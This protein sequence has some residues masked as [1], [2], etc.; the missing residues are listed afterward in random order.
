MFLPL[1]R[2]S[3]AVVLAVVASN[4]IASKEADMMEILVEQ[5]LNVEVFTA[6]KFNQKRSE[7]PSRVTVVD[8]NAIRKYGY[9]TLKDILA[10]VP[11]L[12]ASNDRNYTYLGV[13]GFGLAGDYNT[14][15]L[16]LLD[17]QRVNENVYDS[18]GA[19]Y[20]SIVNV[21]LIKRVEFSSGEVI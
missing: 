20:E 8:D 21:D 15:I 13:R 5:L 3:C 19:D 12:Y 4:A 11:G 6:S 7:A 9:R 2:L 18:F 14:R 10:S 16:L 1:N 17:G